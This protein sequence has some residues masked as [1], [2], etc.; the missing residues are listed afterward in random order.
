MFNIIIITN[1]NEHLFGFW[2]SYSNVRLLT[3]WNDW[4]P[5]PS[6]GKAKEGLLLDSSRSFSTF[7]TTLSKHLQ[8][9]FEG[10]C[11]LVSWNTTF[12]RTQVSLGSDLWVRV[13]LTGTPF[14]DLTDVTLGIEDINSILTDNA[15]RAIQGKV[16]IQV[17]QPGWKICNKCKWPKQPMPVVPSGGRICN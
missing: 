17:T 14:A 4:T 2:L 3:C 15:N 9:R 1:H 11:L 6:T 8:G 13:S 5:T 10:T 16:A 12:Y 7:L